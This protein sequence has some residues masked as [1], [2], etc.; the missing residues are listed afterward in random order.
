MTVENLNI[1]ISRAYR[2]RDTDQ[3]AVVVQV[4]EN[5]APLG[6]PDARIVIGGKSVLDPA[7][8]DRLGRPG[9]FVMRADPAA[10]RTAIDTLREKYGR[11]MP[12]Y[13]NARALPAI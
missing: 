12:V 1:L 9:A 10:V 7:A 13:D 4:R 3:A 11:F 8:F 5:Y 2:D 6:E